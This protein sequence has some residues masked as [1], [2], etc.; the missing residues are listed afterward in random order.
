MLFRHPY[1][2]SHPFKNEL[3]IMLFI[4]R[5]QRSFV[6]CLQSIDRFFS[7]WLVQLI[8]NR[9]KCKLNRI[10]MHTSLIND[11]SSGPNVAFPY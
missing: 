11:F 5:R 8:K 2:F 10:F 6:M 4:V 9:I 3:T 7:A 1:V